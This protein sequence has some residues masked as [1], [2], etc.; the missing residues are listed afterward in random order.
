VQA[1]YQFMPRW[2]VGVRQ[3]RLDSG[4]PLFGLNLVRPGGPTVADFPG[5]APNRPQR[6]TAMIDFSPS[7]FSRFRVQVAR[8]EAR[9]GAS[10]NQWI[11]QYLM[12]LGTHGA[13]KF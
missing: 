2:R 7:E 12:S 5:L 1:A 4:R 10:D 11:L 3:D 6:L 13:H 8:D 9:S